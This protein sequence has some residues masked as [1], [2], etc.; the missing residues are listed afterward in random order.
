M[1]IPQYE[2]FGLDQFVNVKSDSTFRVYGDGE[3]C[4]NSEEIQPEKVL[5]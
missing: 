1:P 3:Y 2:K 5:A 4:P